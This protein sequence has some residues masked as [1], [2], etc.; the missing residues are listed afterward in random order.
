MVAAAPPLG[1]RIGPEG[2]P[3]RTLGW[4]VLGWVT[5]Y[6]LQPDGPDAGDPFRLTDEQARFLLWWYAVDDAGRFV[7]RAGVLRRMKG[8]GKDPL[9]A[10][11]C[12]VE[13]VGPCR[14]DGAMPG[15]D[16]VAVPHY[17]AWVQTAA[18]AKEQTRN[19]M[20]LFPGL[21]SKRAIQEF[22]I[23]LGKEIIYAHRGR[24]RIESVTSSPRALEGGRAT[25][26]LMN[27][28]HHWLDNNE[29]H[30]MADV[31]ARN[32]AK[33]RD[34]SSRTL[35]IT[36]A[37][38]PGED[39]VAERAWEAYVKIAEGKSKA[40]GFLY[41]S[42]EAP[43]DTVLRDRD[44][45]RAGILAARG[46][47]HWLDVDRLIE[48]INDPRTSPSVSR[49]FY[50][51]QIVAAE[52]AWVAPHEW[53]ARAEG[54]HP[55][56]GRSV[57]LG[58]DG[59]K[60]DDHTALVGCDAETGHVFTIGIWDPE[61][62]GGE[63]PREDIDA[64]VKQAFARWDVVGFYSDLS[65]WESYVDKWSEEWGAA[66]CVRASQGHPIAWDFRTHQ[67]AITKASEAFHDAIME[68]VL[69]HDG[70]LT[71]RQHV[72]NARNRLNNYGMTF[73]KEHRGSPR[74]VDWLAAAVLARLCRQDYIALP[75]ARKR[76]RVASPSVYW[77][78]DTDA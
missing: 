41:D 78:G 29:G 45:L 31:I 73:G 77:F 22:G 67:A 20:T 58:F 36:N 3:R 10:V 56:A 21:F 7:Y 46:D 8:W 69:T 24:C 76:R 53:D 32:A 17:S 71:A 1:V 37:H 15:D 51:N 39:S 49:R 74:K 63:A 59:S 38:N 27:E 72:L 19:T 26:V 47:S 25:F 6:L 2:L 33:S 75:D 70:D 62:Y 12:A 35:H 18:V 23:D 55:V 34:G 5:E 54:W 44:S 30:A 9:G 60:S 50:L 64:A 61:N 28:T 13:F 48:E 52:D 4:Q 43:P 14:P 40:T 11:L 57:T 66:L 42:L 16:P 68:G 65:P